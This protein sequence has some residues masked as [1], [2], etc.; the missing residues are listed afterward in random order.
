MKKLSVRLCCLMI[1]ILFLAGGTAVMASELVYIP[2]NPSFGG[3]PFNGPW[4]LK[5][6]QIQDPHGFLK[7][8]KE[9]RI[10]RAARDPLETFKSRLTDRVLYKLSG[11]IIDAAFGE[12]GL[13]PGTYTIGDYTITVATNESGI[14][15]IITDIGTGNTTQIE[16]PYY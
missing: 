8:K 5:S 9:P 6:A 10:S 15:I 4:L 2:I 1:G 13:E 11:E 16:V 12:E 14:N 7:D 3:S